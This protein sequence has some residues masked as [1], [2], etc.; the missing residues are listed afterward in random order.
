MDWTH[1]QFDWNHARAFLLVADEGSLSAAGRAM[2]MSQPTLGRQ[3]SALEDQLKVTLFERVGKGLTLTQSGLRLYE[4]VKQMAD[5]ANEFSLV[6]QGQSNE[7]SGDVCISLTELDAYFRFAP[8]IS[9]FKEFAPNIR[10]EIQV[11]NDISDLKRREADVAIRYQRPTQAD[12]ITKKIGHEKAYLYGHQDYVKHFANKKPQEV[13]N[14]QLI[15]FDRSDQMKN[16]LME[17]GF[18]AKDSHFSV[19]CNNQ[20]VQLQMMLQGGALAFL[21]DHIAANF[22]D[23]QP[24]FVDYFKPIELEMWLVCHRELHTS[25]KVRLVFDFL[26]ENL[27]VI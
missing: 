6:A 18:P 17:M 3:I 8:L 13:N 4:Y 21:P 25:R 10:L 5:A 16:Y 26:S 12:L 22:P 20:L 27:S 15:G 24:A 2:N 19:L 7:V 9:K 1:I 23:L 11:S 14:L